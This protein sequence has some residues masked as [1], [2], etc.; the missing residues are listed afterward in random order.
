MALRK[1]FMGRCEVG[2]CEIGATNMSYQFEIKPEFFNHTYGLRDEETPGSKKSDEYQ[3]KQRVVYRFAPGL[4]RCS[5]SGMPFEEGFQDLLDAA[6]EGRTINVEMLFFEGGTSRA[7]IDAKISNLTLSCSAG[8]NANVSIETVAIGDSYGP[9]EA[10]FNAASDDCIKPVTWADFNISLPFSCDAI[11]EFTF[12][13]N[14]PVK[15]VYTSSTLEH[16]EAS[17]LRI[18]TQEITG[19]VTTSE[20]EHWDHNIGYI[21][22]AAGCD[23]EISHWLKCIFE[24]PAHSGSAGGLCLVTTNFHGVWG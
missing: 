3:E 17:D 1:S 13:I 6:I 2:G 10:E 4:E 24:G 20:G 5:I 14:N 15:P 18:G 12:S 21:S 9:E 23:G 16:H 8:D 19:S 22:F 7:S 11:L